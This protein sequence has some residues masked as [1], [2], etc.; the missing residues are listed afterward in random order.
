MTLVLRLRVRTLPVRRGRSMSKLGRWFCNR[1]GAVPSE[2]GAREDGD[3]DS[4]SHA[5]VC[6]ESSRENAGREPPEEVDGRAGVMRRDAAV[7]YLL[8]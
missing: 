7:Q 5:L 2:D 1:L 8:R 4:A 3:A 6:D